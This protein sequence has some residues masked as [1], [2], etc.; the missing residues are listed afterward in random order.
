MSM[1]TRRVDRS[2]SSELSRRVRN[3]LQKQVQVDLRRLQVEVAGDVVHIRG[4]VE[5]DYARD[6]TATC[7]QRV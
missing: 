5:S 1:Q 3:F 2:D 6:L 4:Q 7:C